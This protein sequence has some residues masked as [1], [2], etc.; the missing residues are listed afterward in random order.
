MAEKSK[1]S[2][3]YVHSIDYFIKKLIDP[4]EE[5]SPDEKPVVKIDDFKE[6]FKIV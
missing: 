3:D 1:D 4:G 5:Y 6:I 2:I